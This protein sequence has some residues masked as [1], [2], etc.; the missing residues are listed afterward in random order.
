MLLARELPYNWSQGSFG[1]KILFLTSKISIFCSGYVQRGHQ[2]SFV[3]KLYSSLV[4][5]MSTF[6]S[7]KLNR[8]IISISSPEYV[9]TV[10]LHE[11]V[12]YST[13]ILYPPMI[14]ENVVRLGTVVVY[15]AMSD[16][17]TG[18]RRTS[19]LNRI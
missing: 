13:Y 11:W 9:H 12:I 7:K 19:N 15:N 18:P 16:S 1:G 5:K 17:N 6:D 14:L 4:E 2:K 8:E 3:E 10:H